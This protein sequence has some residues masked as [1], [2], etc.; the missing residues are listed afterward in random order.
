VEE[1][2]LMNS[3]TLQEFGELLV[4]HVKEM[5]PAEKVAFR[6][7]WLA[8][9]AERERTRPHRYYVAEMRDGEWAVAKFTDRRFLKACGIDPDGDD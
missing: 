8:Q 1:I 4:A 2:E 3:G 7:A 9:V 6:K 5:S